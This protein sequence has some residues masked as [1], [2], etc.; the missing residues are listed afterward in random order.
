LEAIA[1]ELARG[2]HAQ[3]VVIDAGHHFPHLA[4][5]GPEDSPG[6]QFNSALE[7]FLN[8]HRERRPNAS[9]I[10]TSRDPL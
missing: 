5:S 9:A 3:H 10:D 1:E 8:A 2:L 7:A 4:A 6:E